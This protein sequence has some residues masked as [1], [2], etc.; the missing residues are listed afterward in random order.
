MGLALPLTAL[1]ADQDIQQKIDAL[2]KEVEALKQQTKKTEEKSLGRWLTIGGDYRFRYDYLKGNVAPYA[3]FNRFM[4]APADPTT[5]A[6]IGAALSAPG[7]AV[8]GHN[9]ENKS[10]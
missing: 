9:V 6:G 3:N 10:L 7:V 2:T 8:P 1:G 5:M 4:G